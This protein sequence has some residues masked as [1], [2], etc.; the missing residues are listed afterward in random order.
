MTYLARFVTFNIYMLL[1]ML[2]LL[3]THGPCFGC[4]LVRLLALLSDCGGGTEK[5]FQNRGLRRT[6]GEEEKCECLM[7]HAS[8]LVMWLV[9]CL[10]VWLVSDGW[11]P[12]DTKAA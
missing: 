1:L 12:I 4:A 3:L 8:L 10:I 9:L 2:W 6:C 5:Q 11:A 7:S